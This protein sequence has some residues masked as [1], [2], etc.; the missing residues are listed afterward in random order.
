MGKAGKCETTQQGRGI[1]IQQ[2]IWQE[3]GTGQ[4]G[5]ERTRIRLTR[6]RWKAGRGERHNPSE[7]T[8][9]NRWG[10]EDWHKE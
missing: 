3:G 10:R 5:R 2:E 1:E 4:V 6:S 9:A 8:V 7:D